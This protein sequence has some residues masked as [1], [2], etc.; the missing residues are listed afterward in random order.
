M[1]NNKAS[2]ENLETQI[3]KICT[4]LTSLENMVMSE[5]KKADSGE[6]D[7]LKHQVSESSSLKV[8]T[9]KYQK[10]ERKVDRMKTRLEP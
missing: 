9:E 10:R 7:E 5:E 2:I 1:R 4:E 8:P 3:W 6:G